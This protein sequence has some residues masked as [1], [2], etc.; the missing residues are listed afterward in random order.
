MDSILLKYNSL[1]PASQKQVSDY[2]DSIIARMKNLKK[3][4][5]PYKKRILSVSKWSEQDVKTIEKNQAFNEFK[6]EEW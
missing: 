5:S 3:G 6:S 2:I 1:D 4:Q